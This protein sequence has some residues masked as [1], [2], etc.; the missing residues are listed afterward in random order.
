MSLTIQPS[1]VTLTSREKQQ[2]VASSANVNWN[3]SPQKGKLQDGTYQ[4][5]LVLVLSKSVAVTATDPT[6]GETAMATV[7]LS[8]APLWMAAI[9]TLWFL[10]FPTLIAGVLI[11]WPRAP[12]PP[13]IS[14]TVSPPALTLAGSQPQQFVASVG[15]TSDQGVIWS[16]SMGTITPTGLYVAP[17]LTAE[18][19]DQNAVITA[20][21]NADRAQ[22]GTALVIVTKTAGITVTPPVISVKAGQQV[23]FQAIGPKAVTWHI[24]PESKDLDSKG[25]YTA[26]SKIARKGKVVVTA[27][28]TAN[29]AHLASAT[30]NVEP[31]DGNS[32]DDPANSPW[33]LEWRHFA[34]VMVMGALG[35]YLSASRSFVNYVGNRQF[36]PSWG[37]FYL[38]RPSFGIGL[39]LLAYVG[40]RIGAVPGPSGA[41]VGDPFAIAFLAGMVGLFAD[42]TLEKLRELMGVLFRT[43]D[44]RTD[45]MAPGGAVAS[46]DAVSVSAAAGKVTV[47]GKNFVTGARVL[48][49]ETE[50]PTSFGNAGS[51]TATFA[52]A[53]F[54]AGTS[55]NVVVVNPDKQRSAAKS[56]VVAA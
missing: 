11:C 51:L 9:A 52:A 35:T 10:L 21:S 55:V 8:S 47:T 40:Y 19:A 3:L 46:I 27:T 43:N 33:P 26:P 34:L 38:I 53:Q 22:S 7:E 1:R 42:L 45:K 17:Q 13:A 15:G 39:A 4:A 14:V 25:T 37:L 48:F 29:P 5:P 6:T 32:P 12:K 30:I 31:E 36:V 50:L 2:F 49:N 16:A 41:A 44:E 24:F 20:I 56:V 28:D 54:P 23:P 18:Q